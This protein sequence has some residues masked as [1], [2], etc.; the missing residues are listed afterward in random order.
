MFIQT[1]ISISIELTRATR[2]KKVLALSLSNIF[3]IWDGDAQYHIVMV[4]HGV[5]A[6]PEMLHLSKQPR[7]HIERSHLIKKDSQL[8]QTAVN[9]S[10]LWTGIH[11]LRIQLVSQNHTFANTHKSTQAY[12]GP[13]SKF[14]CV[15]DAREVEE[16]LTQPLGYLFIV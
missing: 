16:L 4:R 6:R 2:S 11:V 12:H 10:C 5:L 7:Y 14:R 15:A 1:L 8:V 9:K 3:D 13:V